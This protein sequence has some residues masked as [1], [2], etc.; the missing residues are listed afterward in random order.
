MG[1]SKI[2]ILSTFISLSLSLSLPTHRTTHLSLLPLLCGDGAEFCC[3]I[4][5]VVALIRDLFLQSGEFCGQFEQPFVGFVEFRCESVG[6]EGREKEKEGRKKGEGKG[7][8]FCQI[9]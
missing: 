4:G 9:L 3:Q 7:V 5:S 6:E 8:N 1:H 2:F